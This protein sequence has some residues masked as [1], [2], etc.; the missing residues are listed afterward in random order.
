MIQRHTRNLGQFA[1]AA[2]CLAIALTGC[3]RGAGAPAQAEQPTQAPT[4]TPATAQGATVPPRSVPATPAAPTADSPTSVPA[5]PAHKAPTAISPPALTAADS[6]AAIQT[7]LDYYAAINQQAYDRAYHLWAQNG[8][9]SGQTFD[10]FRQG[11]AGTVQVSVQIGKASA[12]AGAVTVPTAITSVVN[13][14]REEQQVRRFG[15]TYSVQADPNG[16]RLAGA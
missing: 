6:V 1:L 10:Q 12:Q 11:F 7:V 3:G 14:T 4:S 15:G 8:A 16:W 13:V 9:A 2:L 5:S